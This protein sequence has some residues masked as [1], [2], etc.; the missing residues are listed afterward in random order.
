MT[1]NALVF[2]SSIRDP[3]TGIAKSCVVLC[4]SPDDGGWY[5]QEYNFLRRD[6]A[7]RTS[8]KIYA[9]RK[10]LVL[11]LDLGSHCWQKWD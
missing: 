10:D 5:A 6:N 2:Y 4:F 9:T 1:T 8:K 3:R 11:A 7:K